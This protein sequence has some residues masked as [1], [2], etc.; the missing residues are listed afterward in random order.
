M[1]DR[2]LAGF[3]AIILV[4][5][6]LVSFL[7]F[8]IREKEVVRVLAQRT[9]S[10]IPGGVPGSPSYSIDLMA[11]RDLPDLVVRFHFLVNLSVPLVKPWN[12]TTGRSLEDMIANVPRFRETKAFLDSMQA[13]LGGQPTYQVFELELGG[14]M[15]LFDFTDAMAALA[16][17]EILGSVYTVYA[18]LVGEGG[19]VSTF[20]GY[21]DFFFSRNTVI[22]S[23]RYTSPRESICFKSKSAPGEEPCASI[24]EAPFGMLHFHDL[25][26]G[27]RVHL[28]VTLDTLYMFGHAGIIQFVTTE[29]GFGAGPMAINWIGAKSS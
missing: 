16:G 8:G 29:T 11:V 28:E 20:C 13:Q 6:T 19:R 4:I 5:T 12:E 3:L 15:Y 26:A 1:V 14:K 25:S 10:D 18:L 2:R 24:A 17:E 21:R 27:E 7:T 9:P 23:I 22:S